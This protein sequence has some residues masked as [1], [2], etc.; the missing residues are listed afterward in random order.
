MT[1]R[2]QGG[3]FGR[4]PSFNDVEVETLSVSG[5]VDAGNGTLRVDAST[6]YVGVN[7]NPAIDLHVYNASGAWA[8]VEAGAANAFLNL[9]NSAKNYYIY[10][11]NATGKLV[12]FD[13]TAGVER[14]SIGSSGNLLFPSGAGIDF[15]ATSGTG[16]SELFDDYEEGTW[17][18]Q[19]VGYDGAITVNRATYTKT[20]D[21]VHAFFSIT[22][23]GT[24]D[25]TQIN[26]P[27]YSLPFAISSDAAF[28]GLVCDSTG[29]GGDPMFLR[30][31]FTTA[32]YAYNES[33]GAV[34][35]TSMGTGTLVGLFIYQRT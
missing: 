31:E 4:N 12:F 8:R 14:M 20:G 5:D 30:R 3:V 34:T 17:T 25:G 16:T 13:A 35:Y 28:C 26:I 7:V 10:N 19:V 22:F 2:Q 1:I 21:V 18:P 6:G 32:I 33:M 23:D 24:V 11:N 9:K 27:T 15:S 29:S